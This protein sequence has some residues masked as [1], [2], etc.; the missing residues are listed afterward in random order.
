[1]GPKP[2]CPRPA[3]RNRAGRDSASESF[4][5]TGEGLAIGREPTACR[6]QM[7]KARRSG[8]RVLRPVRCLTITDY[9]PT[10]DELREPSTAGH[11]SPFL[12]ALGPMVARPF[13]PSAPFLHSRPFVDQVLVHPQSQRLRGRFVGRRLTKDEP[14]RF[15]SICQS[16]PQRIPGS[17]AYASAG[18]R[19]SPQ[20]MGYRHD[21][22]W[23]PL[24][25]PSTTHSG[26]L[27]RD[28]GG[29][30]SRRGRRRRQCRL[31]RKGQ[32]R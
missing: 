9:L 28:R 23:A 10:L 29:Q 32:A 7:A 5:H 15:T 27:R 26:E 31:G 24:R 22:R 19:H 4:V 13:R 25:E 1:M 30:P 8:S 12:M 17:L 2:P 20:C 3:R 6:A 11:H 16:G 18:D 14:I 21:R